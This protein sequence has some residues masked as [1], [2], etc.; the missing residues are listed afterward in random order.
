MD[1][2]EEQLPQPESSNT[3][4]VDDDVTPEL[5]TPPKRPIEGEAL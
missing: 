5:S 3:D 4:K 1:D 2:D